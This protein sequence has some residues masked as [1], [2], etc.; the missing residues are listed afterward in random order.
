MNKKENPASKQLPLNF[1]TDKWPKQEDFPLNIPTLERKVSS[2]VYDDIEN[3]EEFTIIT[4]FTSLSNLVDL[5]GNKDYKKLKYIRI[6]IGFEPHLK[7]RK[8]YIQTDLEKR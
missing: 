6:V 2:I 3:S 8:D 7:S 1:D 4:G 5:F